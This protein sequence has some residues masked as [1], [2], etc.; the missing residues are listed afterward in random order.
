M[1]KDARGYCID[2][3]CVSVNLFRMTPSFEY[4]NEFGKL[5]IGNDWSERTYNA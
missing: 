2:K 5:L 4:T 1:R 3:K